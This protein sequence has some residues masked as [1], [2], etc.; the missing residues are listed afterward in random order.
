MTKIWANSGDSHFLE[1]E[2]L[3]QKNLPDRLAALVA[4]PGEHRPGRDYQRI[5]QR[6][7]EFA[8][9]RA[10]HEPSVVVAAQQPVHLEGHREPMRR[11]ARQCRRLDEIGQRA[12]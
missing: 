3:W 11:G 7:R 5:G 1:P 9:A 2:D 6:G 10:E 8:Q 4:H 12:R